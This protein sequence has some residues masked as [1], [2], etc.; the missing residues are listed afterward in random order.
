MH[1]ARV[2]KLGQRE[3]GKKWRHVSMSMY[4]DISRVSTSY[5]QLH[6]SGSL[7]DEEDRLHH[8]ARTHTGNKRGGVGAV[9]G[10]FDRRIFNA[11]KNKPLPSRVPYLLSRLGCD[12]T[13]R[14][15]AHVA[16]PNGNKLR[17]FRR[18]EIFI[19]QSV[20]W[21]GEGLVNTGSPSTRGNLFATDSSI[22]R[23]LDERRGATVNR[24][25]TDPCR[26]TTNKRGRDV[27]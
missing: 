6:R 9:G 8:R 22:D 4:L 15:A 12:A 20:H 5:L 26:S 2:V 24:F 23:G 13:R 14:D 11:I 19:G 10:E 21:R 17:I 25:V 27:L 18:G 7:F 1:D 16:F 3:A